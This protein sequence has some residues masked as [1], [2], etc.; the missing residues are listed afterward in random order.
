M[1]S[2][3][4]KHKTSTDGCYNDISS[5]DKFCEKKPK[6][7]CNSNNGGNLF[8]NY[9]N[10]QIDINS[11]HQ[12]DFSMF[13]PA[14]SGTYNDQRFYL[15]PRSPNN[16]QTFALNFIDPKIETSPGIQK[17]W[18]KK[19]GNSKEE[20]KG[21]VNDIDQGDGNFDFPL[22]DKSLNQVFGLPRTHLFSYTE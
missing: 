11:N 15:H 22:T 20:G 5:S 14:I 18:V 21:T 9:L 4:E 13:N 3:N 19:E 16:S 12:Q 1:S 17:K 2:N 6:L 8:Q 10:N 7:S